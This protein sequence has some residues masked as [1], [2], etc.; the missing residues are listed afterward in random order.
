[1]RKVKTEI[2]SQW[3]DLVKMTWGKWV[4]SFKDNLKQNIEEK[5]RSSEKCK[6]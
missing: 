6:N 3:C 1:M 2:R 5:R 4:R